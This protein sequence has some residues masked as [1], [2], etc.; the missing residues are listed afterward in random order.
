MPHQTGEYSIELRAR[1]HL[2]ESDTKPRLHVLREAIPELAACLQDVIRRPPGQVHPAARSVYRSLETGV[3]SASSPQPRHRAKPR[4]R[5][6]EA[7]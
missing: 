5:Q 1:K 2:P 7:P 6:A 4:R 3:R